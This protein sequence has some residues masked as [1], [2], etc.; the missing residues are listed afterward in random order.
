[1]QLAPQL[2]VGDPRHPLD[3]GRPV[4]EQRLE[5]AAPDDPERDLGREPRGGEDRLHAVER[6]ELADEEAG[7]GL[8]RA[9]SRPEEPVLGADEADLD[10]RRREAGERGEE[11]RVRLRVG[12]DQVG[13]A[14]RGAVEGEE[15]ARRDGAG[16]EPPPVLDERLVER[17]ERV[18]DDGPPTRR[19]P[20]DGHVRLARVADE[21]DV[22]VGGHPPREPELG[23]PDPRHGS[24]ARRPVPLPRPHRYVPL[25]D[26]DS[27]TPERRD[28]LRVARI[29]PL[30]RAEMQDPQDRISS[31][32]RSARSRSGARSSWWLVIISLIRPSE[33]NWRPTTT[34]STP[35]V[36][37]GR[38]PIA[39][40]PSLRIVR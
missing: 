31:T 12:D 5:L 29:V 37:S 32:S 11:V 14:E 8:G 13:R 35:S 26:L 25:D 19:A 30:V 27:R 18:E 28:D 23:Q 17:D 24:R 34:R 3:V 36:S 4:G 21:D 33:K 38:P 2:L 39:W 9:P 6:D 16:P 1:M 22:D 10:P 20:R 40:P 15:R 7:P